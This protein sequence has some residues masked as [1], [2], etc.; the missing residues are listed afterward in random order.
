MNQKGSKLTGGAV[1]EEVLASSKTI[2][3][4]SKYT[5]EKGLQQFFTPE[6]VADWIASATGKGH[7][8]L[9][10]T[11]GSGNLLTPHSTGS[12]YGIEID[13]DWTGKDCP[14]D[15]IQADL[16]EIYP[17]A[18]RIGLTFPVIVANPPFGLTWN[19]PSLNE[20]KNVNSTILTYQYC[21][22]LLDDYGQGVLI[23]G[24]DR[25]D[26]EI[27]PMVEAEHIYAIVDV[28]DLFGKTVALSCAI[29]FFANEIRE[30]APEVYR[31]ESMAADLD[32]GLSRLIYNQRGASA[33]VLNLYEPSEI[34][35]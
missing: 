1:T 28:P 3:A 20:G 11:A 33:T 34:Q 14:Y 13:K 17:L 6:L 29:V 18:R 32:E 10:P 25:L 8:T 22:H 27:L 26:R 31:T 5:E 2:L 4:P 19:E 35:R 23:C 24:K 21:L 12:R 7:P 30:S 16:Q 9:D 15:V